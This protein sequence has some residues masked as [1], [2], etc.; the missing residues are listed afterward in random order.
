MEL[1]TLGIP[2]T[3]V[4][5]GFTGDS[6]ISDAGDP[7][8]NDAAW[9]DAFADY[10]KGVLPLDLLDRRIDIEGHTPV[11]LMSRSR[12][13]LEISPPRRSATTR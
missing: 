4:Y 6:G 12:R 2:V 9:S 7:F 5:L 8:A 3:L 10:T 13:V 1:A 11:W